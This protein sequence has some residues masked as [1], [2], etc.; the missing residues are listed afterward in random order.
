MYFG[1]AIDWHALF[2]PSVHV[3]EI[4]LRGTLVYLFLVALFRLLRREAG[5]IGTPD[6]LL[7]VLVADASQNAMANEYKSVTD[8]LVLVST[9]AFWNFAL[10]WATHRFRG[11]KK[12]LE[13][14]PLLVIRDGQVLQKNLRKEMLG[15]G[16]L[17]SLLREKGIESP[18]EVKRGYL[19]SDGELSVIRKRGAADSTR[20]PGGP[21]R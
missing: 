10:D 1:I 18:A 12:L 6:L 5:A 19:E 14:A 8:G 11:L 9:L 4:V 17:R 21:A 15:I 20:S 13:P 7:V 2:V 3:L 16:D